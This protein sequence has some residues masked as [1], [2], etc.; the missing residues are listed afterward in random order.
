M[1]KFLNKNLLIIFAVLVANSL[2]CFAEAEGEFVRRPMKEFG[3]TKIY[4]SIGVLDIDE[5]DS[6]KQSFVANIFY[7]I[8]W[9]DLRLKH[10]QKGRNVVPLNSIWH[11]QL[12]FVN[13]Q[14]VW[15]SLPEVAHISPAGEVIYRQHV[16]GPFSQP[17]DVRKFPFDKQDFVIR[18]ACADYSTNEIQFLLDK[19]A[20]SGIADEFSLPDW[21]ILKWELV[22]NPY[23]PTGLSKGSAS[24]ALVLYAQRYASHYIWKVILP[25]FLIV[26]MSWVV[27]WIDPSEAGAQISVGTT[28]MLTLIAYR[29]MVGDSMP[30]VPYLTRIDYFILGSTF[31]VFLALLQV[32]VTSGLA[33]K[34]KL[35]RARRFDFWSRFIFPIIFT[36]IIYFSLISG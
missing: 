13:Q 28:S 20:Q 10:N 25:L 31:L 15:S 30:T 8:R 19:G 34:N 26:A 21:K 14:K 17:L 16:W 2:N 29:F 24:F 23:K 4:V 9:Y 27:F 36:A 3:P 7:E 12:L 6:A 32:V 35:N 22:F 5:I 11:P 1:L 33:K 18:I